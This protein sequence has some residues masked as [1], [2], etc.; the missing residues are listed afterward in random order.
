[1]EKGLEDEI[2]E[3]D[4][5]SYE[6]LANSWLHAKEY[7][8]A[9]EPLAKGAELAENGVLYQRLGA[10]HIERE[11]WSKATSALE[12]AFKKGD[13]DCPGTAHLLSGIAWYHQGKNDGAKKK[14]RRAHDVEKT[15]EAAIE[16]MQLVDRGI[17]KRK[18]RAR[19]AAS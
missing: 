14:L 8:A 12:K 9:L 19:G 17:E 6:M 4:V 13:L 7:D 5:Q 15:R 1:M 10:V 3:G 2:I 16:W 18:E 11:R